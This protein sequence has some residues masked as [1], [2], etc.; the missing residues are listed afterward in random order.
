MTQVELEDALGLSVAELKARLRYRDLT[1]L[2]V[3]KK[4]SANWRN[5]RS[6][7][8]QAITKILIEE[9]GF[10]SNDVLRA[11]R[12]VKRRRL[13]KCPKIRQAYLT[14]SGEN[15]LASALQMLVESFEPHK[16]VL[17]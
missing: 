4:E 16:N 17:F 15:L 8:L 13:I 12:W 10:T 2:A 3:L 7:P 14:Q 11:A 5:T 9:H 1:Y 6:V